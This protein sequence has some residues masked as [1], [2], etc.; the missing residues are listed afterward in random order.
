[1]FGS[2]SEDAD[3]T[4]EKVGEAGGEEGE[5]KVVFERF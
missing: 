4:A 5:G 3:E 2:F 1:M